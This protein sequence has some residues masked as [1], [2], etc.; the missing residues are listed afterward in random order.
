M[1]HACVLLSLF[2]SWRKKWSHNIFLISSASAPR[3]KAWNRA[4]NYVAASAW[5]DR[6]QNA[7]WTKEMI[8]SYRNGFSAY[9]LR[10]ER[11]EQ[12]LFHLMFSLQETEMKMSPSFCSWIIWTVKAL[13]LLPWNSWSSHRIQLLK[14]KLS[15]PDKTQNLENCYLSRHKMPLKM[16][17]MMMNCI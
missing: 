3:E 7:T 6:W 10:E 13:L 8:D 5:S 12:E 4:L 9:L 11:S 2:H 16:M 17:M 14:I 15:V 1:T